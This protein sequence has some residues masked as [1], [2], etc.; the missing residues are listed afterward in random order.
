MSD[1][2]DIENSPP[3]SQEHRRPSSKASKG[4][5]RLTLSA[6][7]S[8]SRG[9]GK[10]QSSRRGLVV[11]DNGLEERKASN[12][13]DGEKW[14]CD[15]CTL[16]NHP[17]LTHC[18]VCDAV[19][20]AG[21]EQGDFYDLYDDDDEEQ[22]GFEEVILAASSK[23]LHAVPDVID[24]EGD[25]DFEPGSL[26]G[27]NR[28]ARGCGSCDD[29]IEEFDEDDGWEGGEPQPSFPEISDSFM[30]VSDLKR[31]GLCGINFDSLMM[32]SVNSRDY[33]KKI[34]KMEDRATAKVQ[35]EEK[36]KEEKRKAKARKPKAA[37]TAKKN[38]RKPSYYHKKKK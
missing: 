22:E 31:Y 34:R 37:K 35:R 8:A 33:D 20:P 23:A 19:R 25:D 9:S 18:E 3:N 29:E 30:T 7:K 27:I 16:D 6:S 1:I 28:G 32:K 17:A 36:K 11:E 14:K 21:G 12:D 5:S 4:R 15:H 26:V 10:A 38:F 2:D 13:E 24:D